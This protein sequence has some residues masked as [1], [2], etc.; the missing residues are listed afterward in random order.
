MQAKQLGAFPQTVTRSS[1]TNCGLREEQPLPT[2]AAELESYILSPSTFPIVNMCTKAFGDDMHALHTDS[3][4]IKQ[5]H[6]QNK[7]ASVL[8]AQN[9]QCCCQ[10]S[11]F[12]FTKVTRSRGW[13]AKKF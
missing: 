10:T 6:S 3:H 4:G 13:H 5:S 2:A 12:W 11:L 7:L 8:I 1:K 9:F